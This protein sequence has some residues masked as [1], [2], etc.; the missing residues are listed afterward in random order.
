VALTIKLGVRELVEFT[1]RTGD[2]VPAIVKIRRYWAHAS[3]VACKNSAEKITK[4]NITSIKTS[5]SMAKTTCCTAEP[6]A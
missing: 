3:T 2:Q 1:L 5:L 4:K 6:M